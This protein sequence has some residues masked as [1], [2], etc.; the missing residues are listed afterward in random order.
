MTDLPP[1]WE[2]AT[3]DELVCTDG[4]FTD[5]DWVESKDQDPDGDVRLI[6][7]AD[8]GEGPPM[9]PNGFAAH[10]CGQGTFLSLEC[11]NCWDGHVSTR[12]ESARP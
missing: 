8:V 2:W 11:Q 10:S 6:Q 7:L 9:L 4:C 5:G 1:G 3:L 12:E